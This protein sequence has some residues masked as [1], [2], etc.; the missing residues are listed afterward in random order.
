MRPT[1][2]NAAS[3]GCSWSGRPASWWVRC[4]PTSMRSAGSRRRHLL[5]RL[6][7]L[8]HRVVRASCAGADA[9]DDRRR[10]GEPA[11]A[12]AAAAVGLAAARPE[13]ARRGHPVP[14]HA[15]LQRQHHRRPGP[16]R[17]GCRRQDRHVWRPDLF[18]SMLFLVSS[19]FAM[20]AVRIGSSAASRGPLPWRIALAEHDRLRPVHGLGPGQLR[21]ARHRRCAQRPGRRGRH[22]ARRL[23]L[24]RRARP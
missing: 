21:P 13:L 16:Q 8:H 2:L 24:P 11:H 9:G 18:G 7:L 4:R 12:G 1:F 6:D 20:L 14:G 5:R 17:H 3:R 23:V 22:A 10:R 15:V 19:A